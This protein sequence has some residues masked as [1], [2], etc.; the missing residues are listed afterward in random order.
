ML[1]NLIEYGKLLTYNEPLILTNKYGLIAE[2]HDKPFHF[3]FSFNQINLIVSLM[4][5]TC[6]IVEQL[7]KVYHD[8]ILKGFPAS[9]SYLTTATLTH[10]IVPYVRH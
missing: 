1:Y 10:G 9:V 8:L 6:L 2:V 5:W 4:S 3:L 7:Y